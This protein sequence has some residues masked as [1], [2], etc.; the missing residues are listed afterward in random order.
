MPWCPKC[1]NE[2]YSDVKICPDC[3]EPLVEDLNAYDEEQKRKQR[4]EFLEEM[5]AYREAALQEETEGLGDTRDETSV[6]DMQEKDPAE[7]PEMTEEE[8]SEKI[9]GETGSEDLPGMRP[10]ATYYRDSAD[11]AEDNRS[12]AAVLLIVGGVGLIL[13]VLCALGV[14]PI[15]QYSANRY[16]TIGVMAAMFIIFIVMGI[17]SFKS[18]RQYS[19]KAERE[20]E[21]RSELTKWCTDNLKAGKIDEG[22]ETSEEELLYFERT[23]RMKKVIREN[24]LNLDE[25]L[26]DHFVDEYY[27]ALFEEKE[28]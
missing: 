21:L 25:G 4:E 28:S 27:P 7:D 2:Y 16:M 9:L 18:A 5:K 17:V 26:L 11:K 22:L 12:S 19:G 23:N 24:F 8:L 10:V 20:K 1:R 13:A 6:E 3:N 14:I 15:F